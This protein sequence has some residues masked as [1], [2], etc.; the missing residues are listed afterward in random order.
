MVKISYTATDR[1]KNPDYTI[2]LPADDQKPSEQQYQIDDS[3]LRDA[4]HRENIILRELMN[5]VTDV[6]EEVV[7]SLNVLTERKRELLKGEEMT[8]EQYTKI[9][10]EI[11]DKFFTS[12]RS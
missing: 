8:L 1:E 6:L 2:Q 5:E 11:R 7:N 4:V 3:E 9:Q 12:S 10:E